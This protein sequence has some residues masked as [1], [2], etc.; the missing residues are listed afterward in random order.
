MKLLAI[1]PG[2]TST[3]IGIFEDE[4]LLVEHVLRHQAGDLQNFEQITDQ[5]DFRKSIIINTL[6]KEGFRVE[7]FDA[8]V[9]RG[10]L[11]KPI[12]GGTYLVNE[13]LLEDLRIGVQGQHASNL[14]GL[15]A[16]EIAKQIGKPAFIVD[17]VVVDE[18]KDIARISGHPL[19][20]RRSIFHA[21]NQ[22]ATAH[23]YAKDIGKKY[24]ELNLIVAHMGGGISV[25]IHEKGF[26][27][28]TNNALDG[29][30]PFAPQR[31]GGL[32]A[33]A[34]VSL[35]F[36]GNH[37]LNQVK[38]ML[39][40]KGGLI[41]YTGM[42]DIQELEKRGKTEPEVQL[43]ID[44]L[45][46]QVSKE[47]AAMAVAVNGQVDAIL[48]TGGI[49]YSDYITS[50]ITKRISFVG[51]VKR[52]PGENELEALAMGALRVLRGEEETKIYD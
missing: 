49:A 52:Y 10:G 48:L 34:L 13:R 8:I 42:D 39:V 51:E 45:I 20:P 5:Y 25:G 47:I 17:P 40:G 24:E 30:G 29:D 23:K 16:S 36:N 28:D 12:V 21:L 38:S 11:V 1:N 15:I 32:P 44:A 35:C 22:K 31:S 46:Y 41:A 14:G 9:G 18:L 43:L 4:K 6:I 50:E 7:D 3:K 19:L 37:S 33:G 26:V 2:S 27:I